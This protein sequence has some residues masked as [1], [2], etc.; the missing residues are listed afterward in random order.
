M[1]VHRSPHDH[2][3]HTTPAACFK[4]KLVYNGC[5][6]ATCEPGKSGLTPSLTF[7]S[8]NLQFVKCCPHPQPSRR[9]TS[10]V[11]LDDYSRQGQIVRFT[12]ELCVLVGRP[13]RGVTTG[14]TRPSPRHFAA[15]NLIVSP[16]IWPCQV[17]SRAKWR[18]PRSCRRPEDVLY[19][20]RYGSV[21]Q[22]AEQVTLN[23]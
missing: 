2:S 9:G 18:L 7:A 6:H 12:T 4:S 5:T 3:D 23:H 10:I 13:V 21:A 15:G 8:L 19:L 17:K 1:T 11:P 20:S 22:L 14:T 16:L